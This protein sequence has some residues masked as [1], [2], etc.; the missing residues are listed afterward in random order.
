LCIIDFFLKIIA[1]RE[2]QS[3]LQD[4]LHRI[5]DHDIASQNVD[6]R[7]RLEKDLTAVKERLSHYDR[8][9]ISTQSQSQMSIITS[10]GDRSTV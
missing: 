6:E 10:A 7:V 4:S 1:L 3:S 8:T 5:R 2:R 9:I